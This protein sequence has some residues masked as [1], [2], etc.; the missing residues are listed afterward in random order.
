MSQHLVAHKP[1]LIEKQR[2]HG[3]LSLI[4]LFGP[5]EKEETY[6]KV[7]NGQ[8]RVTD[9]VR[10]LSFNHPVIFLCKISKTVKS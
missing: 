4:L 2:V 5:A 10:I 8:E 6:A 1:E 3:V 7:L 9:R